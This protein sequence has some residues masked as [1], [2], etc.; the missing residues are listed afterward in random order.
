[1]ARVIGG[2]LLMVAALSAVGRFEIFGL[3]W[4][5][6]DAA[7]WKLEGEGA[8]GVLHLVTGREPLPGPRRPYQFALAETGAFERLK[9]EADVKPLGRSL[10][11]V[12]AYHDPAHF[13]YAH[14][15]TD[16]G[17]K[18]PVHNG[19]FHVYGG[20]RVRISSEAGPPAFEATGRWYHVELNYDGASGAVEV[21]VDGKTLPALRAVDVSLGSGKIGI[22]SFDETAD[23]R[24][25]KIEEK[26]GE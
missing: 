8:G 2:I 13:D 22:G 15:S 10:L 9:I 24:H 1:M 5:V 4:E 18:Q 16:T 19:I 17:V 11:L 6:P 21:K 25:V 23:F 12:F 26:K 20:E 7:D 3:A 14:L